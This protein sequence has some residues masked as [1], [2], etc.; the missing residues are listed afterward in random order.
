MLIFLRILGVWGHAWPRWAANWDPGPL[1]SISGAT[2]STILVPEWGPKGY[3]NVL[4]INKKSIQNSIKKTVWFWMA[5]LLDFGGFVEPKCNE[6]E[7]T[8]DS[9]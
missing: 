8:I 9:N 7:S 2:I 3:Q 5:F 1:G 4:E 6:F